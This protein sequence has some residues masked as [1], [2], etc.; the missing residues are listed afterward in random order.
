VNSDGPASKAGIKLGETI[1]SING[2]KIKKM[3][4]VFKVLGFSK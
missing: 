4:D 3:Y 1:K 2:I